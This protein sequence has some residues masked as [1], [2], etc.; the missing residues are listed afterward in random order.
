[1]Y[2]CGCTAYGFRTEL[3]SI[4]GAIIYV[5]LLGQGREGRAMENRCGYFCTTLYDART[6]T[7]KVCV[8][9]ATVDVV[10][11]PVYG[12]CILCTRMRGGDSS[13]DI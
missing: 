2:I 11:R 1:M 7:H 10:R 6:V 9:V 3:V 5:A 8:V 13:I 4:I 12:D